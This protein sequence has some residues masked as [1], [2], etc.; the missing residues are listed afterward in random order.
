MSTD[1]TRWIGVRDAL[2]GKPPSEIRVLCPRGH[3]IA[4]VQVTVPHQD[5]LGGDNPAIFIAPRAPEGLSFGH[6][7]TLGDVFD[8]QDP[9]FR[10]YIGKGWRVAMQCKRAKCGW[11]GSFDYDGLSFDLAREV[12]AGHA[13][14]R[15]TN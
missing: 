12:I 10:M 14:Y 3:F 4:N 2:Q 1:R 5:I 15:L 11:R 9:Q 8:E 13:K 7:Q 6:G